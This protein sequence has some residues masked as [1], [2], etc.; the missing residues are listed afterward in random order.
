LFGGMR[1]A[2][3]DRRQD[4]GDIGHRPL[5][6][7]EGLRRTTS[8]TPDAGGG[9]VAASRLWTCQVLPAR[10][11]TIA[12]CATR[13]VSSPGFFRHAVTDSESL[14]WDGS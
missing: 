10:G 3:L 1:V 2:L 6:K 7:G 8:P 4:V 11:E 12:K 14:L 9:I 13:V 5:R